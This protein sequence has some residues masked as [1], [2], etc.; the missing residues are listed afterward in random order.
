MGEITTIKLDVAELTFRYA[1][2]VP[3]VGGD[4]AAAADVNTGVAVLRETGTAAVRG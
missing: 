3:G 1:V 2:W 4:S